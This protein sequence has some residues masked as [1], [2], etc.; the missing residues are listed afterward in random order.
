MKPKSANYFVMKPTLS[1]R[2]TLDRYRSNKM[3]SWGASDQVRAS[4]AAFRAEYEAKAND[5]SLTDDE[6]LIAAMTPYDSFQRPLAFLALVEEGFAPFRDKTVLARSLM[7]EW[8]S[9][10]LPSNYDWSDVFATIRNVDL[11]ALMDDEQRPFLDALPDQVTLYRGGGHFTRACGHSWSIDRAV[12]EWFAAGV[13]GD[14]N[15]R[16][17]VWTVTV[18]K[19]AVAFVLVDRQEKECVLFERPE[20]PV[21]AKNL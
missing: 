17:V 2:E 14:N 13:R 11:R 5:T 21:V 9:F 1:Y 18:P 20:K 4:D 7:G 19:S 10:D 3:S 6:R 12:S 16:P 8:S 15:P